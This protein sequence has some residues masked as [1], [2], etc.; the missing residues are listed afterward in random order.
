MNRSNQSPE[1]LSRMY[2]GIINHFPGL[3]YQ[4]L[5]DS[6]CTM[7]YA[8]AGC[9]E[10]T[11]WE[12][13]DFI[14]NSTKSFCDIIIKDDLETLS[15]A[16]DEGIKAN[17]SFEAEYRIETKSSE[18]KWVREL[19]R[20]VINTETNEIE[21]IEGVITDISN[22]KD[23]SSQLEEQGLRISQIM[24]VADIG[25]LL[26]DRTGQIKDV[27]ES[28]TRMTG[29]D[30]MQVVNKK[31]ITL[32]NKFLKPKNIS[33]IIPVIIQGLLGNKTEPFELTFNKR[34]IRIDTADTS[35]ENIL[36]FFTD[37]T[38][39]KEYEDTIQRAK[40]KSRESDRLK[41]S[42]LANMS[43]EIRTPM[44]GILGFSELLRDSELADEDKLRFI[45]II[46]ANSEQLLHIIDDVLDLSKIE[47]GRLGIY[48]EKFDPYILL[49]DLTNTTNILVKQKPITVA[50]KYDL[51]IKATVVS[52]KK[53][54]KQILFHLISN[55]L[56]F[57]ETGHIE[58]GCYRN[59]WEYIEF[60]VKDSGIGIPNTVGQKIFERFRQGQEGDTRPY[61]GS[62]LGLSLSKAMVNLLGGQIGFTS[63]EGKGSH[64][65]FTLPDVLKSL[66]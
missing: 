18:I 25:I 40:L 2:S 46:H 64:F 33:A 10:L 3:A 13:D 29:L 38:S 23:T 12:V 47:A 42:F 31:A 6:K 50:L 20:A 34:I 39:Q 32:A 8:S 4:S 53:R 48:P 15:I 27:N 28:F 36:A 24:K 65:Y 45:D 44:N 22:E 16:K 61:G 55:A 7:L 1:E 51:P 17:K 60:F 37:I 26:V 49:K 5:Y 9:L 21:F 59:S 30:K 11:G 14:L 58:I 63:I 57:T 35:N 66:D 43:H 52:D 41:S 56:K 54:V 62:G 19:G